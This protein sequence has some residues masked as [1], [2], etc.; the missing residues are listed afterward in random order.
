MTELLP[1][2]ADRD[3][4]A[5]FC[6]WL[7]ADHDKAKAIRSGALDDDEGV[8]AFAA[9]RQSTEAVIVAWLR[10]HPIIEYK[11]EVAWDDLADALEQGMHHG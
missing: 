10:T 2:Q 4:A 6:I 7:I 1:T 5:D 3:A 11:S 9:H 8:Q